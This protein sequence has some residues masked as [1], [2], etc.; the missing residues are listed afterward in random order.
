MLPNKSFIHYL[1]QIEQL[2]EVVSQHIESNQLDELSFLKSRLNKDMFPFWQQLATAI[3]FSLRICC[4]LADKNIVIMDVHDNLESLK[5]STKDT[6]E[7]LEGLS[8]EFDGWQNRVIE[9]RAGFANLSLSGEDY[10]HL[11][12]MPNFLFHMSM[13]YA[14]LRDQEV[15]VSKGHFDGFHQYP[16]NFSFL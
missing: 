3:N 10:L 12:G 16:V 14:I 7:Y 13:G 9:T 8:S 2:L 6:I 5:W 4:P 11:Y 1:K 15:S